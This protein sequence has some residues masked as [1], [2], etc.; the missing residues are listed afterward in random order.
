MKNE[1][2]P[3]PHFLYILVAASAVGKSDLMRQMQKESLWKSVPK[4]SSRDVRYKDGEIDDVVEL[5]GLQIKDMPEDQRAKARGERI[6]LLKE[7]CGDG[8]GVVYYKNGNLYGIVV[9][10]VLNIME[11]T[12]AIAIISDFHAI[13][14]LKTEFAELQDRIRILYIASSIDER[15]LLERYKKRETTEFNLV[16][17]KEKEVLSKI[18]EFNSVVASATRLHYIQRIEEVMPLLNEEW[19]SILPYFETIKTY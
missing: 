5:D 19:N 15:V 16:P 7:R 13:A 10:E 18:G 3:G 11:N 12:N 1:C 8:K 6:K 9:Q 14:Q 2:L 4:Y 17:E